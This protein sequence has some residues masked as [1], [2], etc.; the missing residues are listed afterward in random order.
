MEI[1]L[2]IQQ[3]GIVVLMGLIFGS[4]GVYLGY[5]RGLKDISRW[6]LLRKSKKVR[7]N[8]LREGDE[9]VIVE[10]NVQET[11]KYGKLESPLTGEECVAYKYEIKK[12][13]P[14]SDNNSTTIDSGSDSVPF[15]IEEEYDRVYVEPEDGRFSMEDEIEDHSEIKPEKLRGGSI[16]IG[17]LSLSSYDNI[18]YRER[19]IEIDN[20]GI[21]LGKATDTSMDADFKIERTGGNL[22]LSDTNPESTK[23]RL[24][25]NGAGFSIL[26]GIFF[27][28]SIF[29]FYLIVAGIV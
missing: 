12:K 25:L 11:S 23:R 2:S 24:I 20:N 26:G 17:S 4:A 27:V 7:I 10:G 13:D 28:F 14:G 19:E 1:F 3:T 22:I 15:Y 29:L 16:D 9:P 5:H 21:V 8:Q 18:L 6:L